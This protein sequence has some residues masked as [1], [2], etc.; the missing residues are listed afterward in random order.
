M[1]EKRIA[2]LRHRDDEWFD[3]IRI[4]TLPRYKTSELSGDE[5]RIS[6]QIQFYR[7]GKL[8]YQKGYLN[9]ETAIMFLGS[10]WTKA[11]EQSVDDPMNELCFQPGC[12]EP[13]IAEYRLKAE[14]DKSGNKSVSKF[15]EWRRR[16][17]SRHLRRGDCGLEDADANYEI[18]SG[19]GP[20]DSTMPEEDVSQASVRFLDMTE[21]DPQSDEFGKKLKNG[22]DQI[23]DE[24][25]GDD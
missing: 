13:F 15:T 2:F 6:G 19:A 12:S 20:E 8:L 18:V 14:Y 11:R 16:F 24:I 9:L 17:C 25:K 4:I 7:K 5:W 23:V 10:E 1:K 22:L 21:V 3:E